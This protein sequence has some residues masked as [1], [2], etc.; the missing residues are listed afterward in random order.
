MNFDD[1]TNEIIVPIIALAVTNVV[2]AQFN[3]R[4]L[5][6][7]VNALVLGS[8]IAAVSYSALIIL[9]QKNIE[10]K[11]A[12]LG[13]LTAEMFVFKKKWESAPSLTI[14]LLALF[15]YMKSIE[16]S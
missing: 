8:F 6:P 9:R 13:L 11:A 3:T 14:M 2:Y 10:S 5:P 1:N 16:E 12:L 4:T 7:Q 15:Y